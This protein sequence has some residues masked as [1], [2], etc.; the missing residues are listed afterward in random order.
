MMALPPIDK[1]MEP[2]VATSEPL[3]D[4]NHADSVGKL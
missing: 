4:E 1:V 3:L 2:G